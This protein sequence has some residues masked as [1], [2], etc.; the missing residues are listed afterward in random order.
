MI[1]SDVTNQ[2]LKELACINENTDSFTN[3]FSSVFTIISFAASLVTVIGI[4]LVFLEYKKRKVGKEWQKRIVLDLYRHFMMNNAILEVIRS[5]TE[6]FKLQVHP[7]EGVL[8]RFCTLESDADLGRFAVNEQNYEKVH[9]LSLKIR[10]YNSFSILAD[11]HICKPNYPKDIIRLE[12]N[13]IFQR[14]VKISEG[15]LGLLSNDNKLSQNAILE[16]LRNTYGNE[17]KAQWIKEGKYI[18]DLKLYPRNDFPEHS[19]YDT[20]GTAETS[21]LQG[22]FNDMIFNRASDIIFVEFEDYTKQQ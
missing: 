20:K 22:L 4:V 19:Y 15:L 5:K 9:E 13:E 12:I 11:R 2:V 3:V 6:D 17:Q 21:Q 18:A 1:Q 8:S 14:G 16:Y 10:N 7:L